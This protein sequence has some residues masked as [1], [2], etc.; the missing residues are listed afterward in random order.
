MP[1][2]QPPSAV[3]I[4]LAPASFARSWTASALKLV[5]NSWLA[6]VVEGVA[7]ALTATQALGLDTR[8]FL[9]AVKGGALD[10]PFVGLKGGVA[11]VEG[12]PCLVF[13]HGGILRCGRAPVWHM[14][15]PGS[16]TRFSV[17]DFL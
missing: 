9:D 15:L 4:A 14:T 5:V 10:A 6:T 13:T 7:E 3:T 2:R 17:G 11:P 8:L 12:R 1:R 16:M